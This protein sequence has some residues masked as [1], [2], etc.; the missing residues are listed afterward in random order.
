IT[1][2]ALKDPII[3]EIVKTRAKTI[4]S[5]GSPSIRYEL[6]NTNTLLGAVKGISGAKT[7]W[8]DAAQGVL[9]TVVTRNGHEIITVVM[10]SANREED[11]RTLI[12]WA[13]AN[14]EW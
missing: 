4:Y 5:L 14:F 8:T 3:S 9:T 2:Y 11:T 1:D 10:H 7:G 13:Y 6:E 12:E